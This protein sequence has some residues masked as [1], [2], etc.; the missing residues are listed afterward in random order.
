MSAEEMWDNALGDMDRTKAPSY[1]MNSKFP[2]NSLI[3][4]PTFGI[5]LIKTVIKPNKI[6]VIFRDGTKMLR[7][8]G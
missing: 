6:E 5:G 1:D 4:H 7:C 8:G 2:A 3:S